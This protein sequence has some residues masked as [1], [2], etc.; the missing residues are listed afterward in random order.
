MSSLSL[1]LGKHGS[2][3]V[4]LTFQ[5]KTTTATIDDLKKIVPELKLSYP[6]LFGE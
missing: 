2:I 4:L 3:R 5:I 6:G 1:A